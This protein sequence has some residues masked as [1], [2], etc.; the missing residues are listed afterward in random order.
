MQGA[1][2]CNSL[3]HRRT[4]AD[5]SYRRIEMIENVQDRTRRACLE[6]GGELDGLLGGEGRVHM[7]AEALRR[8]PQQPQ[9][10]AR[11]PAGNTGMCNFA[12]LWRGVM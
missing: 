11:K 9:V 2:L 7:Q 8:G 1:F 6:R 5:A 3:I 10:A 12:A 4:F